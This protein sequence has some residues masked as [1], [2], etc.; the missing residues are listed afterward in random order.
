MKT[1]GIV[2]DDWKLAIFKHHLDQANLKFTRHA[3]PSS[4]VILL[5]VQARFAFEAKPIVEA[6]NAECSRIKDN[7]TLLHHAVRQSK[8]LSGVTFTSFEG[9]S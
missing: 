6:A 9:K 4:G 7:P 8:A 2:I 5:K 3:L 1:I